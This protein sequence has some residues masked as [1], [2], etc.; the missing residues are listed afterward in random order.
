MERYYDSD[1]EK[2]FKDA[3]VINPFNKPVTVP[4]PKV[5][6]AMLWKCFV[7]IIV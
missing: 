5:K 3:H 2:L 7:I 1:Q 6:L 4:K